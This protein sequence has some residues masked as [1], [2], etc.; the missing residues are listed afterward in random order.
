MAREK[1]DKYQHFPTHFG[2]S[3]SLE[4][5][6]EISRQSVKSTYPI[7]SLKVGVFL[8]N[9][10]ARFWLVKFFQQ[11]VPCSEIITPNKT[12]NQWKKKKNQDFLV[13]I[14]TDHDFPGRAP[15]CNIFFLYRSV[16][17]NSGRPPNNGQRRQ[18]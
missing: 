16:Q 1:C 3:L 12:P 5:S 15:H 17:F 14:T 9:S 8:Q 10:N 11:L 6:G 4:C 2:L 13:S 7:I 18:R